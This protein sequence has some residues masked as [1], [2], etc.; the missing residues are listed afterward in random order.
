VV[1][2]KLPV[3]QERTSFLGSIRLG[4]AMEGDKQLQR[5]LEEG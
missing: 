4:G 1:T 3:P 5:V 2:S